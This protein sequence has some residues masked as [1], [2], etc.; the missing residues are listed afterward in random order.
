VRGGR[1]ANPHRHR[2]RILPAVAFL[3]A[4][5]AAAF[6]RARDGKGAEATIDLENPV[7]FPAVLK[8]GALLAAVMVATDLLSRS[9]GSTGLYVLSAIT[10]LTDVDAITLST[11]RLAAGG[12]PL[13]PAAT[14]ILIAAG[15]NAVAK[16]A[17]AAAAGSRRFAIV[18]G[19]GLAA[20]AFAGLAGLALFS[21]G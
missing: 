16:S 2:R 15:A 11:A 5:T 7:D 9:F 21:S 4:A 17:I 13:R 12:Y 3:A 14:A 1:T 18:V 6:A 8:F 10:G 20:A 19:A